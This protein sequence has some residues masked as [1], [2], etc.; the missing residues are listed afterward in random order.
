MTTTRVAPIVGEGVHTEVDGCVLSIDRPLP[1][2]CV[3]RDDDDIAGLVAGQ[4]SYLFASR[5]ANASDVLASVV[6]EL[7]DRF[8]TVLVL[9]LWSGSEALRVHATPDDADSA[10]VRCLREALDDI[11]ATELNTTDAP[12]PP[13]THPVLSHDDVRKAGCLILGL[14]VPATFVDAVTGERLPL[15]YRELQAKLQSALNRAFFEFASVQTSLQVQ[16]YRAL[17]RERVG[18]SVLAVD[19]ALVEIAEQL[20]F[21]LAVTPVNT[22][23]A[24]VE[25]QASDFETAPSLHY[26]PLRIDPDEIKRRLFEIDVE[27]VEDPTLAALFRSKRHELDRVLTMLESRDS[28][29]FFGGSLQLYGG[30]SDEVSTFARQVLERI[31]ETE[32]ASS[33]EPLVGAEEIAARAHEEVSSYAG[34]NSTVEIR[35]D[36]PAILVANGNVLIGSRLLVPAS[37]V[38]ALLAHEVGT[39]VVTHANG[40]EQKI[41]QLQVGL[42][43][44]EQ[45]QEGL[46]TLAEY[47]VGGLTAHRLATIA[48]R[49]MA[50]SSLCGGASFVETFRMLTRDWEFT[51]AAAF[52]ISTR[53]HRCGGLTK[54]AI[55]LR[56]LSEVLTYLGS[57]G[58]VDVLLVGKLP[59]QDVG[60]V[61]ELLWRNVLRPATVRPRWVDG[62]R[63]EDVRAGKT[64]SDLAEE[65]CS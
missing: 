31:R 52:T 2:I 55:Y 1:F 46:A 44:Y 49:V 10:T 60:M 30:V 26:R 5:R 38:D 16:D 50:V 62:E 54:D 8:G 21:L 15:V 19:S 63:M 25:F 23:E 45:T 48:G 39:H 9:E 20:D 40:A 61:E 42:P 14:E 28:E 58:A 47:V 41:R 34:V 18:D 12:S 7:T 24:W 59:L 13:D 64:V 53:V 36:V 51:N 27:T 65:V 56:G 3:V 29:A 4:S 11:S 33:D 35:D 17:G 37:R 32:R 22:D 57:G 43:G 6:R